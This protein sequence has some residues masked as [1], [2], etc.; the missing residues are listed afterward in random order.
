MITGLST[1]SISH[2][3]KVDITMPDQMS[4]TAQSLVVCH[5]A[6]WIKLGKR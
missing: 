3:R 2:N 5:R 1:F 6:Q 4:P